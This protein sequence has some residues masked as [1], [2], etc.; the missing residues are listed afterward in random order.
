MAH[1][2][3]HARRRQAE[4]LLDEAAEEGAQSETIDSRKRRAAPWIGSVGDGV[5]SGLSRILDQDLGTAQEVVD[6]QDGKRL[7]A[8]PYGPNVTAF[9]QAQLSVEIHSLL[10]ISNDLRK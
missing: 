4:G 1:F 9:V 8:D 5:E 10:S 3:N 7:P 6:D 2:T